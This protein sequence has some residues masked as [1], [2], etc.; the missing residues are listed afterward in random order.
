MFGV[1]ETCLP[2]CSRTRWSRRM[3]LRCLLAAAVSGVSPLYCPRGKNGG[4]AVVSVPPPLPL[5][6]PP[7]GPNT[8][9]DGAAGA[10]KFTLEVRQRRRDVDI[11]HGRLHGRRHGTQ[12]RR[13]CKE[14]GKRHLR[15][16]KTT[17]PYGFADG[18]LVT[19]EW[20]WNARFYRRAWSDVDQETSRTLAALLFN[21]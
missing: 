8:S 5:P 4:V 11:G 6:L 3:I 15:T 7:A 2:A 19:W 10:G 21:C 18:S 9:L 1:S 12:G 17:P 14:T 16:T 13:R 20:A